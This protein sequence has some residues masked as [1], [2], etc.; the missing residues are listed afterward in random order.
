MELLDP[1]R[2]CRIDTDGSGAL[3]PTEFE[4]A[5]RDANVGLNNKEINLLLS[6]ADANQDGIVSQ[7]EAVQSTFDAC[8]QHFEDNRRALKKAFEG[9]DADSSGQISAKEMSDYI[10]KVYGGYA[11]PTPDSSASHNCSPLPALA[12]QII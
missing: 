5:L 8:K 10:A 4:R 11:V 2:R 9:V 7:Q 12:S 6:E 1:C 3:D